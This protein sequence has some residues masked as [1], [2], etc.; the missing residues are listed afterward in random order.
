MVGVSASE[1]NRAEVIKA[2]CSG[3]F[4]L[5]HDRGGFKACGDS[6]LGQRQVEDV[7][8]DL[9]QLSSTGPELTS[10]VA[11]R[12]SSLKCSSPAQFSTHID[13]GDCKGWW[14]AGNTLLMASSCLCMHVFISQNAER[15]LQLLW[16]IV[17]NIK[18]DK[19]GSYSTV[20]KGL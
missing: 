1:C 8:Q 9:C 11:I 16:G 19:W 15:A 12:A 13:E 2:C 10:R 6:C 18:S 20:E 4:Q 7:S 5:W 17:F 14:S 3:V